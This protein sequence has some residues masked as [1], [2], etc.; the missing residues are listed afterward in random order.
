MFCPSSSPKTTCSG[1]RR[2]QDLADTRFALLVD[3]RDQIGLVRFRGDV[4]VLTDAAPVNVGG[5]AGRADSRVQKIPLL[6]GKVRL[7]MA[8]RYPIAGYADKALL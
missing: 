1:I 4:Q 8:L 3:A 5:G 6:L 7:L 2:E